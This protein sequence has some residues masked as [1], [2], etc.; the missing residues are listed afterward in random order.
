MKDEMYLKTEMDKFQPGGD[1]D[2][3]GDD[4]NSS[5]EGD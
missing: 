3:T 4:E 1:E 2:K 5:G